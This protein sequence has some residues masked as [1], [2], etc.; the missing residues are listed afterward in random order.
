MDSE[1]R[2]ELKENDLATAITTAKDWWGKHQMKVLSTAVVVA[3]LILAIR[4]FSATAAN[5]RDGEQY[6]LAT[7]PGPDAFRKLAQATGSESVMVQA[8]LR[9]G[10]AI[11]TELRKPT[12]T[13]P[14][15]VAA[16]KKKQLTESAEGMF[17]AVLEEAKH[18]LIRI[19]ARF[20]LAAIAETRGDWKKAAEQYQA[21]KKEGGEGYE[22]LT[23]RAAA[24]ETALA[25]IQVEP[26]YGRDEPKN[27]FGLD[28]DGKTLPPG[29]FPLFPEDKNKDGKSPFLPIDPDKDKNKEK[30]GASPFL[31]IIPSK[32]KEKDKD[33]KAP[34][35]PT[36]E[37]D[38]KPA[39][40]PAPEKDA[41]P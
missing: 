9:G 14:D 41:K 8:S 24:F 33:G 35:V 21:I 16:D 20:G 15:Q 19:K 4:Y 25:R 31:P 37:K 29:D 40:V 39:P 36:P 27:P 17:K 13:G 7:A 23:K 30:D 26:I 32:D 1:H 2:H 3:A 5:T 22:Y 38:A 34:V 28:K 11:L 6:E 12:G 18:P 10:D